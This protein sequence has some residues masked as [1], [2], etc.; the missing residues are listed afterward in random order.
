MN[1]KRVR[2]LLPFVLMVLWTPLVSSCGSRGSSESNPTSTTPPSIVA[3]NRPW[4]GILDPSRGVDWSYA[5]AGPIPARTDIC[6]TLNPTSSLTGA[7]LTGTEISDA[8]AACPAGQTVKL[9]PGTYNLSNG[10]NFTTSTPNVTLRGSGPDQTFLVMSGATNCGYIGSICVLSSTDDQDA[11][12]NVTDWTA[13]YAKGTTTITIGANRTGTVKPDVGW[14]L[15]LDQELDTTETGD[16]YVCM[17]TPACTQAGNGGSLSTHG[18][19]SLRA[20]FQP[21]TI[22]SISAGSCPCTVEISPP[23]YMPNWRSGKSPQAWW[24]DRAPITGIGIEDLSVDHTNNG[25]IFGIIFYN[26]TNSWIKNVRSVSNGGPEAN[27][28][29]VR[30]FQSVNIT[31]RDSYFFGRKGPDDYGINCYYCAYILAENN[32]IQR[33]GT[34]IVN[35]GGVGNVMAYNYTIFNYWSSSGGTEYTWAQGSFYNHN[36]GGGWLLIEG[37]DGFGITLE[38]Y[39][40]PAFFVTGFRNRLRGYEEGTTPT[41]VNQTVP[42][43]NYGL[44]RYNNFIGNILGTKGYHTVYQDNA[45]DTGVCDLAIWSIGHGDN[46]GT[47]DGTTKPLDDPFTVKTIMRWGN[48]DTVNDAARF[49]AT[50]VPSGLTLYANPVPAS[51]ALPASFYLSAKPSW[52]GSVPWPTI[53]PDVTGGSEANVGGHNHRNPARRCFED[54]MHGTLGDPTARPFNA[55][56]CQ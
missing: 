54:V 2:L 20:Q 5:G 16:V 42:V 40:G 44:S 37:N 50:E 51:Q 15:F 32:I 33:I 24:T 25:N 48:Y 35:E 52:Y 18:V 36:A 23:I 19:G 29:H 31:I 41:L 13:G 28:R 55:N 21:V 46:C 9:N 17:L 53:G 39:F 10:I 3:Q 38:N 26:A 49:V 8:I 11:P 30:N 6:K 47:G 1:S 22:T 34:P 4:S 12:P 56:L 43:L 7:A 14:I 27:F 45:N